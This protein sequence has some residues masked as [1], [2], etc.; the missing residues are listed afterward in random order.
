MALYYVL[1]VFATAAEGGPTN[2]PWDASPRSKGQSPPVSAKDVQIYH[3]V[4]ILNRFHDRRP[5]KILPIISAHNVLP[6]V[7]PAPF[8]SPS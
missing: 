7:S 1:R 3:M 8:S 6:M 5:F 4:L 2:D